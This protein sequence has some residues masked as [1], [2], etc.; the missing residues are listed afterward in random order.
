MGTVK[1]YIQYKITKLTD[2]EINHNEINYSSKQS[3]I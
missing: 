2:I 1:W 3:I